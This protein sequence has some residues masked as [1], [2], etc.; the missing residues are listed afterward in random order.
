MAKK[1][2]KKKEEAVK[3]DKKIVSVK[4][5]K[6]DVKILG[7]SEKKTE[8]SGLEEQIEEPQIK[9]NFNNFLNPIKIPDATLKPIANQPAQVISRNER[10]TLEEE[11]EG[12]SITRISSNQQIRYLPNE[13][14]S[15]YEIRASKYDGTSA[16]DRTETPKISITEN[17]SSSGTIPFFRRNTQN[18]DFQDENSRINQNSN[19]DYEPQRD[20]ISGEVF[21][22]RNAL[23]FEETRKYKRRF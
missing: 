17:F 22:E 20:F 9:E 5:I 16:R 3:K 11:V 7:D 23:P 15:G 6:S 18:V 13:R 10:E 8:E 19:S 1:E 12:E 14:N 4:E 21:E 2:I